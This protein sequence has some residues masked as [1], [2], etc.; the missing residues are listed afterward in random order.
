MSI[1]FWR[2]SGGLEVVALTGFALES[3]FSASALVS[4]DSSVSSDSAFGLLDSLAMRDSLSCV[5][6][7]SDFLLTL[8]E[9]AG[10]AFGEDNG[11][12]FEFF[13]LPATALS[14]PSD[15]GF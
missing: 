13:G 15:C 14:A 4:S 1:W 8:S 11:A 7:A 12:E 6:C 10:I 9:S 3:G 5:A 2:G